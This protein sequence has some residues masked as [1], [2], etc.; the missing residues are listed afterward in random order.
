VKPVA[1]KTRF[2]LPLQAKQCVEWIGKGGD[3]AAPHAAV[4]VGA[5][6]NQTLELSPLAAIDLGWFLALSRGSA[7]AAVSVRF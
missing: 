2:E 3:H 6:N 1:C 5:K 4:G 7:K